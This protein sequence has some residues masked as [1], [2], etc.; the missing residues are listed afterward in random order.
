MKT[1]AK[2]FIHYKQKNGIE[3]ASV[4]TPRRESGKKV[5]DPIYLGR[6]IDKENGI[7]KNRKQGLFTYDIAKGYGDISI[8]TLEAIQDLVLSKREKLI[9][10]FGDA[11]FLFNALKKNGI[12]EILSGILPGQEDT[13]MSLLG[14]RLLAGLSNCHA[15]DWWQGSYCRMLFPKAKLRSQRLSELYEELGDEQTHRD[16]W[17][18]YLLNV[19]PENR[20]GVLI[21]STGMPNDIQFPLTAVVTH[22]GVTDN[23]TRLLLVVDRKTGMPLFFRY[24]AGNIVDVTTLRSTIEE[25]RAFGITTEYAIVD[26]GYYSEDN[27]RCL[28]GEDETGEKTGELIPFITRLKP[29]LTLYKQLVSE[30]CDDILSAKYMLFQRDRLISVKCVETKLHGYPGYAYVSVDHAR[31]EDEIRKYMKSAIENDDVSRDEMDNAIKSKGFFIIISSEKIE[32]SDLLPLYYTRQSIEQIFD[33]SKNNTDLLPLRIHNEE[34]FRGHLMLNFMATVAY[35][36]VNQMLKNTRFNAQGAFLVMKNQKCKVFDDFILPKEPSK[37][38]NEIYKVLNSKS[39]LRLS[40]GR[41]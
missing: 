6:V 9:L 33:V 20:A 14:Y 3:Y 30:Y 2:S 24:N 17:K 39:P 25:L 16:F 41:K 4:F 5:N 19:C 32:T 27:I 21:D 37:K 8:E 29:N 38:A 12:Y 34:T 15:E 40:C 13:V 31:R 28:Y 18:S 23:E 35:L 10:D 7:Y 1:L 26:A 36:T 22:G 11:F